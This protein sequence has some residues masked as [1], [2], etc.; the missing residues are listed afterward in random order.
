[1]Y[2]P[3][4]SDSSTRQSA[5]TICATR[6]ASRV[7]VA[8]A[9]LG[10]CHGVVLVDHRHR[11][12]RQQSIQGAACI[13]IAAALFGVAQ[14]QQDLRDGDLVRIQQFLVGVRQSDLSYSGRCLTFL[15]F[16]LPLVQSEVAPS[17]RNGARGHHND[18]L[19]ALPY[20]SDIRRKGLEPGTIQAGFVGIHQQCGPDFDDDALG[21]GQTA[22]GE[23]T[24]GDGHGIPILPFT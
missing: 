15:E 19:T 9:D 1:V 13:Q 18:I 3:S 7:I 17:E 2:K 20:G 8:V 12:Q 23:F 16:E 14:G 11:A 22:G 4:I 24:V 10:R 21:V 6:A 5:P